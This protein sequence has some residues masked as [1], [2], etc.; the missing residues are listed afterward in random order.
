MGFL[1]LPQKIRLLC[2]TDKI[3]DGQYVNFWM[4]HKIPQS[5][6]CRCIQSSKGVPKA[7]V[8]HGSSLQ[9]LRNAKV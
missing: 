9:R 8:L 3:D 1:T 4:T 6:T 7:P 5:R 2:A